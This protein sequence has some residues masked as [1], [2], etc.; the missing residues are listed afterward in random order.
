MYAIYSML[1]LAWFGLALCGVGTLA[2]GV[3]VA[4]KPM[5]KRSIWSD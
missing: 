1:S 3:A 2:F 4:V 5:H